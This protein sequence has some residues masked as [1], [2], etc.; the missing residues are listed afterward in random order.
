MF[1]CVYE[2]L[3]LDIPTRIAVR[4]LWIAQILLQ[5]MPQISCALKSIITIIL[6]KAFIVDLIIWQFQKRPGASVAKK[7]N[8]HN[9]RDIKMQI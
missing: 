7:N 8:K 5:D 9:R 6:F 1:A 2:N 3:S 4:S